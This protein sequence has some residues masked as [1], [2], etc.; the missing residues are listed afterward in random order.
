MNSP[1]DISI[2]NFISH[3]QAV[4]TALGSPGSETAYL[5]TNPHTFKIPYPQVITRGGADNLA[6]HIA[7]IGEFLGAQPPGSPTDVVDSYS[8]L[9]LKPLGFKRWFSTD[10][11]FRAP[12]AVETG[13]VAK[14][15]PKIHVVETPSELLEFDLAAAAGFGQQGGDRVY[16]DRLLTDDRYRFLYIKHAGE[17]VAGVQTFTN[18]E[19]VGIYTLFTL[20][21]HRRKGF[22]SELVH[23]ALA[24]EPQL[25]A[26]TNPGWCPQIVLDP[27]F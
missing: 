20:P 9:D 21:D 7:E 1:I 18:S 23:A 5:S 14:S 10:W 4:P 2:N 25:P 6:T 27:I 12:G 26:I 24:T 19:S 3:C 8:C 17:I 15:T 11:S 22:A 16:V 13:R